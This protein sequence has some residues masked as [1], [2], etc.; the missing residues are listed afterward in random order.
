MPQGLRFF[1]GLGGFMPDGDEY[2]IRLAKG[3]NTPAP[4][5]NV[6]A[7]PNFGTLVSESGQA[8]TWT[9]NAHEFRLT[10]WDNDP[11]Q[12]S[13]GEA[14]YL[15]DD[16]TGQFWSPTALPCR[17]AGDY[18]TR[19]GF[20]Y[21]V[22]EHI[23][24][25]IYSELWMYVALDAPVKFIVLKVRN[26]SMRK[27]QLSA[28]GYVEWVLGDL[29]SKNAMHVITELS[30]S[31]ALLAQNHYNTPFG[32]RTAFFD[33]ATSRL[34]L[35]ARTVTG[36]RAEFIGR[37]RTRQRPAA[38]IHQ[39]LSGRVGAGLDPCGAIQLAFDLAEGQS[40]EIIFT[41]GAGQNKHDADT[42][43]QRYHG[44]TAAVDA[45][46]AIRQ[47]W[48]NT[49]SAVRVTTPDPAVDF[50]A[51]GW[52]LYQVLSSRLWGRTGYYQSSGAFGFRDQLQDVM[53]LVHATPELL[54]AHLLLCA[55]RQFI[56]GDV[57]HWW[58]PPEGRGVRTRC[59]D[60][61]LWLPF[62]ICR[63][64]E[65]TGDVAVLDEQ[66]A[67][68]QGPPLKADEESYYEL[69]TISSEHSSLYQHGVRA[70][71]HGLRFGEHG[72]PLM[73]SGDWNDG[74]NLVGA[75]GRGESVWL[76]FFL[77][78]VLKRF[79]LLAHRYGDSVFAARCNMES[80]QLQ[81]HL[82]QN[83]WDG[84]WYRRAYFDDGTPLGSA[85]NIE[86]RIDSIAQ[87]WSV[88]SGAAEPTRAKLAMAALN[89]YLVR[90]E[91]GLIKLLEPP[92]NRSTP[93]PGY[94]E[95]YVPGIRENGGQ[96]TH[97][98]VWAVMAFVEL[99][100][101]ELAWQLFNMMNPINHGRTHAVI[102]IY[103]IEPYVTAG[104]VYSVAPHIGNG[105]WSWYTGS[106][107]WMYR[108]IIESLLG[109]QLEE[110]RQL[111]LTP[112][113][114]ENWDGFT[115]DYRYKETLYQIVVNRGSVG[116]SIMLDGVLLD[117]NIIPLLD[118]RKIHHVSL[119]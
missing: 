64:V 101:N 37:N 79:A 87:S 49:L 13:S 12:D 60:D 100:E 69:P 106:A 22:F 88:L 90:A 75:K 116:D 46:L 72:L 113:L 9:E 62:A 2:I 15:R 56:E 38:L 58:H 17:G 18:L 4:W 34:G 33:A 32:E 16:E 86:C 111:R 1:N 76:G 99:G 92:F 57:Q 47:Y 102:N 27:R 43:A 117:R 3:N 45:L 6:L 63:Y 74:M 78:T 29:R 30:R 55:S 107:G 73:G 97:A 66:I 108:L 14:F 118:D 104:D 42:F 98:A 115:L 77:Y 26:D 84:E 89:H 80:I 65:A 5:I 41:L 11:V 109:L 20:G 96:Y 71:L 44:S 10:P 25:G 48:R 23:E 40:R 51:N 85:N 35:N 114:P 59:S 54:R 70:V 7:N 21:S 93:N 119:T 67:F 50:L 110:G 68:L 83:A 95:G 52:L 91:D 39:Q 19:H 61:Y 8:Y 31:G 82:E 28:I 81:Q 105:G 94:I 36:S 53:A 103:K 112:H 24:N